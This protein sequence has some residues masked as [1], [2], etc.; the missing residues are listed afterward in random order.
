M[1]INWSTV[2]ALHTNPVEIFVR[3]TVT[4][5]AILLL[6]RFTFKRETGTT[7]MTDL[8][9]LVLLADAAQNAMSGNYQSVTDGLLLVGTLVFWTIAIDALAYRFPRFRRLVQPKPLVL[10]RN[11]TCGAS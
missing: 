9:V 7:S 10:V 8:L 3:G 2:F 11:G 1:A 6:L 4:Y 5:L